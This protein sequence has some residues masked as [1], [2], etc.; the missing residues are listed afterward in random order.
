MIEFSETTISAGRYVNV[1]AFNIEGDDGD[2]LGRVYLHADGDWV[3]NPP[4]DQV[5]I[6]EE[7]ELEA[8]LAKLKELNS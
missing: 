1:P 7:W 5:G 2:N 4:L 3:Y 8:V 6:S